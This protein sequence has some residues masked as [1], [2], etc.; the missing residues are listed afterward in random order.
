MLWLHFRC[1]CS[2]SIPKPGSPLPWHGSQPE[3]LCRMRAASPGRGQA[4]LGREGEEA[5]AQAE[6]QV[7]SISWPPNTERWGPKGCLPATRRWHILQ[8][9]GGSH[10]L[11]CHELVWESQPITFGDGGLSNASLTFLGGSKPEDAFVF[12][13]LIFSAVQLAP[14]SGASFHFCKPT[15]VCLSFLF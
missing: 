5:P 2:C 12:P 4:C 1:F 14:C 11:I 3:C 7:V 13:F 8:V 6:L 10:I 15:P 9:L